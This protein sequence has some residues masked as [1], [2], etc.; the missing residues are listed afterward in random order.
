MTNKKKKLSR[1]DKFKPLKKEL[2]PMSTTP[3]FL[4]NTYEISI[5]TDSGLFQVEDGVF[6]KL[7]RLEIGDTSVK[8]QEV[9][10]ILRGYDC[11]YRIYH[12]QDN[13]YLSI[14]F[15]SEKADVWVACN[16]LYKNMSSQFSELSI[17]VE[18]IDANERMKIIHGLILDNENLPFYKSYMDNDFILDWKEDFELSSLREEIDYFFKKDDKYKIFYIREFSDNISKF[19]SEIS[20]MEDIKGII[21]QFDPV[22]DRAVQAFFKKNYMGTDNL[23]ENMLRNN[24]DVYSIYTQEIKDDSRY[25]T[26]C[27]VIFLARVNDP[28]VEEK[29]NFSAERYD[30]EVSYFHVNMIDIYKEFL[31][32]G[33]WQLSESRVVTSEFASNILLSNYLAQEEQGESIDDFLL[34]IEVNEKTKE[35]DEKFY[36]IDEYDDNDNYE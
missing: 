34:D 31:P 36:D 9:F 10:T 4:K 21:T 17:S 19:I 24:P 28:E 15:N 32:V 27:G 20:E 18:D 3:L 14:L 26:M 33:K 30:I 25:F 5:M 7:Y 29:I 22:S 12:F 23:L 11:K 16:D 1:K 6:S 2:I 35:E 13:I 8:A